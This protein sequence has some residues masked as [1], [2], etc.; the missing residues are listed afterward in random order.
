M[1]EGSTEKDPVLFYINYGVLEDAT[2]LCIRIHYSRCIH[3]LKQIST[4]RVKIPITQLKTKQM[5]QSVSVCPHVSHGLSESSAA[6]AVPS[7]RILDN[8]HCLRWTTPSINL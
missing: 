2:V 4:N 8:Y 5:N 1:I 3:C 6:L 7:C